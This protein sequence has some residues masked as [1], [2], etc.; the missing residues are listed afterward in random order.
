MLEKFQQPPHIFNQ[1]LVYEDDIYDDM[2][3][4]HSLDPLI[5]RHG[6]L[7]RLCWNQPC[8]KLQHGEMAKWE[9]STWKMATWEMVK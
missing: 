1:V 9:T 5:S 8:G 4:G 3:N 7:L 6:L 2:G